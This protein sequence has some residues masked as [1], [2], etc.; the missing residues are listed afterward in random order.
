MLQRKKQKKK[1]V[2]TTKTLKKT[3]NIG[4]FKQQFLVKH[5][6]QL[7]MIIITSIVFGF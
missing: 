5:H 1:M 3:H 6:K 4:G 7:S 2:I